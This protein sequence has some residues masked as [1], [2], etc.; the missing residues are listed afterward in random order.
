MTLR[1]KAQTHSASTTHSATSTNGARGRH[2][3]QVTG[4]LRPQIGGG[5]GD[6]VDQLARRA[7]EPDLAQPDRGLHGAFR[8]VREL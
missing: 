1:E 6:Q 5:F 3:S 7:R 4:I 8:V 2:S